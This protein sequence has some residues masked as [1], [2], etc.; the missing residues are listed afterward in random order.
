MS[1]PFRAHFR[2]LILFRTGVVSENMQGLGAKLRK[3]PGQAKICTPPGGEVIAKICV[4]RSK[5]LYSRRDF[6]TDASYVDHFFLSPPSGGG[7]VSHREFRRRCY[8]NNRVPPP[9]PPISSSSSPSSSPSSLVSVGGPFAK[10]CTPHPEISA[11]LRKYALET[12][13]VADCE[14]MH[15]A[16][17]ILSPYEPYSRRGV[18][19]HTHAL[20]VWTACEM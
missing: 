6:A 14:N 10:I 13:P 7:Y 16:K 8:Q 20:T 3:L 12:S 2:F 5:D 19:V 17:I 9:L 1:L 4:L 15:F 18:F 11:N